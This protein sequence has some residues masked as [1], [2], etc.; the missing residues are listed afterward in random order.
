M[1]FLD[2]LLGSKKKTAS[3]AKDR[4]K[5]ILAHERSAGAPDFLPALQA[6]LLTVI[7]K[8]IPVEKDQISVHMERRGDFEVL[9]LNIL[10]PDQH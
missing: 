3:V 1:S 6:E 7:S 8:Y 4:L 9:E 5:L 10:F 2:Y